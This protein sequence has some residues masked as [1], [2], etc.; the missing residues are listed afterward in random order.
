MFKYF[1]NLSVGQKLKQ[2]MI[3]VVHGHPCPLLNKDW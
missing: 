3:N 1:S 2:N